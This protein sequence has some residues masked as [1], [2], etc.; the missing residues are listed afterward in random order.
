MDSKKKGKIDYKLHKNH[1]AP[2]TIPTAEY[3]SRTAISKIK[4][5]SSLVATASRFSRLRFID[6]Y[7]WI[8]VRSYTL[9]V[10]WVTTPHFCVFFPI[11]SWSCGVS[12]MIFVCSVLP[13]PVSTAVLLKLRTTA[14]YLI[15]LISFLIW[16]HKV[17]KFLCTWDCPIFICHVS[18][19][20]RAYIRIYKHNDVCITLSYN[21][22]TQTKTKE[23]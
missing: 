7:F 23:G 21:T 15:L 9:P 22:Q 20:I 8:Q 6:L 10:L 14:V 1:L 12:P 19:Q 13:W 11:F 5:Y 2:Q 3:L 17:V 4:I 16:T 18:I